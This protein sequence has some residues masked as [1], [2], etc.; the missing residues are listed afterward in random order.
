MTFSASTPSRRAR[1]F[2]VVLAVTWALHLSARTV[3]A[4]AP[5]VQ[6]S[7]NPADKQQPR[8][9]TDISG[10]PGQGLTVDVD[11]AFSLNIRGRLQAR[12]QLSIAQ[13]DADG[14]RALDQLV[15]INT[16]RVYLSGHVL[17]PNLFYLFQFA[18][19]GRD[20]RDGATSPIFDAYLDYKPHRDINVQV[21]QFFVPFDRLRTVREW[22]LQLADRPRPVQE[23][24]L[25]RDVG[26]VL[27]SDHLFAK[28]SP[29]AVRLGAFGGGGTNLVNGRTPGGLFVGRVELRPLG[30]IDDDREGDLERKPTP[31]LALGAAVAL[32]LNTNRV[33][34]TTGATYKSP[35]TSSYT[36]GT[37]D[38]THVA[39]DLVFKWSGFALQAEYLLR[40]AARNRVLSKDAAG[41]QV[42]EFSR[43]GYG[44]ILQ[45]S[46]VF[47]KP[48]ELVGRVSRMYAL[49]GTDPNFI[50]EVESKGQE[51]AAGANYYINGHRFKLQADWIGRL[52]Y[53]FERPE[54]LIHV[55]VDAT[56]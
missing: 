23:L 32:N 12:Y 19:A 37:V 42:V 20:Y 44:W 47:P 39:T 40:N 4:D 50:A 29:V 21:G 46:Y 38:Y 6:L 36:G 18:F 14:H 51:L 31:R 13:P 17:V 10:A 33:R 25:D 52:N 9:P 8:R 7:A 3:M 53:Q 56:F 5:S 16:L 45:A 2:G 34:S 11:D 41:E 55:Q 26:V 24:T 22:A 1:L 43:S 27:Y 54:H 15:N 30:A 48:V 49:S 35:T 28:E